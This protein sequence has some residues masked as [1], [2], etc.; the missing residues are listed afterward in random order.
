MKKVLIQ[1]ACIF[2]FISMFA[3]IFQ[4]SY[5]PY[6]M[7][8]TLAKFR[9]LRSA[10]NT[11]DEE[12]FSE[13]MQNVD[14]FGMIRDLD[15]GRKW[16][17]LVDSYYLLD[18]SDWSGLEDIYIRST[19]DCL[20]NKIESLIVS[21]VFQ[22]FSIRVLPETTYYSDL[23]FN[24]DYELSFSLETSEG[25]TVLFYRCYS[26]HY[27]LLKN[28]EVDIII[29]V[30]FFDE[31]I[32]EKTLMSH[33]EKVPYC[34]VRELTSDYEDDLS[35]VVFVDKPTDFAIVVLWIALP[36]GVAVIAGGVASVL[37]L[38]KKGKRKQSV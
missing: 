34:T 20:G 13:I 11:S 3:M 32:D 21:Y 16:L 29:E 17:A 12:R 19:Y 25:E 24:E 27:A 36:V 30:E 38:R 23:E 10:I 37:I 28:N 1:F 7:T 5:K 18:F 2:A 6:G 4:G 22:G 14:S 33:M 8:F 35:G 15:E 9:E 31:S 26:S